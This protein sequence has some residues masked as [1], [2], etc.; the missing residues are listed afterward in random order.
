MGERQVAHTESWLKANINKVR[1]KKLIKSDRDGLNA[2]VS[3]KGKIVFMFRYYYNGSEG[4]QPPFRQAAT[5]FAQ[6][7]STHGWIKKRK[8]G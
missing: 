6:C 8:T 7:V 2:R 3:P 4:I 5:F 1:D